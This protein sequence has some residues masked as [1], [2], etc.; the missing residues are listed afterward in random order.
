MSASKLCPGA[1]A[2]AAKP[3]TTT[4]SMKFPAA[5]AAFM[6]DGERIRLSTSSFPVQTRIPMPPAPARRLAP[7]TGLRHRCAH[8]HSIALVFSLPVLA[9][10]L[11]FVTYTETSKQFDVAVVCASFSLFQLLRQPMVF[12]PRTLSAIADVCKALVHLSLVFRAPLREGAPFV[13]DLE[14]DA[15]VWA[16]GQGEE[17]EGRQGEGEANEEEHTHG[18]DEPPF[19][20]HDFTLSI[21]RGTLA[22]VVG[23]VGSGKSSLLKGLIGEMRLTDTRHWRERGVLSA[24]GVDPECDFERQRAFRA[25]VRGGQVL[26]RHRGF[27]FAPGF[28]APRGWGLDGGGQKQHVNIARALYYGVDV[29]ILDDPLS[30]VDANVG[31][32]LFSSAIQGLCDYIHARWGRIA[33]AGTYGR[34]FAPLDREFMGAKAEDVG[35]EGGAGENGDGDEAQMQVVSVEDAFLEKISTTIFCP[36]VSRLHCREDPA[37]VAKRTELAQRMKML[38]GVRKDLVAFEQ[39]NR[40]GQ[41]GIPLGLF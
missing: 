2:A 18:P 31:K 14:Q 40:R 5:N 20:L 15:A 30:A 11:T 35:G 21:P 32:A 39:R 6:P 23:H 8:F 19:A 38:E 4:S 34:E 12:L 1:S 16:K 25:A 29:V 27:A 3:T 41:R 26:A 33:E 9:A 36:F 13:V 37:I 28:A 24:V 7:S 22:A 10:T 17:R